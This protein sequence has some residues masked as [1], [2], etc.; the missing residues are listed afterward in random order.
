MRGLGISINTGITQDQSDIGYPISG[1]VVD[2][3]E[4][5]R[6]LEQCFES[7]RRAREDQEYEEWLADLRAEG[8]ESISDVDED[9][10]RVRDL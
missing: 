5:Q 3:D 9:E 1:S 8:R 4:F 7:S 10:Q 2:R 6:L